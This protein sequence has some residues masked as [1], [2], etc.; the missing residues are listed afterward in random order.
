MRTKRGSGSEGYVL[1]ITIVAIIIISFTAVLVMNLTFARFRE[2]A[3]RADRSKALY[4]AEHAVQYAFQRIQKDI[5][6][7][8]T[9]Y[10]YPIPPPPGPGGGPN[11]GLARHIWWVYY[12]GGSIGHQPYYVFTSRPV[13]DLTPIIIDGV[14]II[15]PDLRTDDLFSGTVGPPRKGKEV[16]LRMQFRDADGLPATIDAEPTPA[17]APIQIRVFTDYGEATEGF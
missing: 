2:A 8:P 3:F 16:N 5:T 7:N 10:A 17:T 14:T 6:W 11:D 1:L 12:W 13:S 9:N 4:A 15:T